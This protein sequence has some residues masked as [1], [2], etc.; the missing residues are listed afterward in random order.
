MTAIGGTK[1]QALL[2]LRWRSAVTCCVTRES[3]EPLVGQST[4]PSKERRNVHRQ[5]ISCIIIRSRYDPFH[6]FGDRRE[7]SYYAIGLS[8]RGRYLHSVPIILIWCGLAGQC[9]AAL[10]SWHT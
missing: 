6:A 1:I 7:I 9:A 10:Q 4:R 5:P 2:V 3:L 8:N